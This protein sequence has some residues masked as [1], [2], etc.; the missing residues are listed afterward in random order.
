MMKTTIALTLL[1]LSGCTNTPKEHAAKAN[2]HIT[3]SVFTR[4][5]SLAVVTNVKDFFK[6]FD[7]RE[8]QKMNDI[9]DPT[10]TIIHHNGVTTN[11][12]EMITIIK[13]TKNWWPRTRKLSQFECIADA[14]LAIVG[15][16]NEVIFSLPENKAVVEPYR[17]TWIFKRIENQWKA[18]RCHYSK[19]TVD[20]HSEE[21]Q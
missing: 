9:M 16:H 21:V 15:L 3:A 14:D 4:S 18:V 20:K 7:E 11:R 17:E 8:L 12:E 19:I 5:D 1:L 13:E 6:A 2:E 10:M